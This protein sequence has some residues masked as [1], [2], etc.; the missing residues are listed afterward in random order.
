MHDVFHVLVLRRYISD[1]SH[2]IDLNFIA[3]IERGCSHSGP[4]C[5]KRGCM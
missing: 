4:K 5:N 2:V 3:D 1:M